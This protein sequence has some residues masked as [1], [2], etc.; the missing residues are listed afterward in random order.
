M[1]EVCQLCTDFCPYVLEKKLAK[2]ARYVIKIAADI[3]RRRQ[4]IIENV[5]ERYR[6]F[7]DIAYQYT[8]LW[9]V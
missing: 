8:F 4:T 9:V 5:D 3:F 7:F 6:S 2:D 1:C